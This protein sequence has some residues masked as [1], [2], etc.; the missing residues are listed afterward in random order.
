MIGLYFEVMAIKAYG[1]FAA[2]EKMQRVRTRISQKRNSG[3]RGGPGAGLRQMQKAIIDGTD[4][5]R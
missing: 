3:P 4:R 1:L 2:M 5:P